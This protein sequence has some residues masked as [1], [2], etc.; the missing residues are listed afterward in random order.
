MSNI[1]HVEY[2]DLFAGEANYCWVK[3]FDFDCTGMTDLQ[4]VRHVKAELGISGKRSKHGW[5][6]ED[7]AR[8]FDQTV[9][10]ITFDY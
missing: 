4:I 2:T 5:N 8:Y 1:A 10:F 3:R 9:L 7:I 6:G